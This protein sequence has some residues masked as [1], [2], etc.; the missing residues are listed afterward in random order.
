MLTPVAAAGLALLQIAAGIFHA[1]RAAF[2]KLPV[3]AL[4]L[5][6]A[7]FVIIGRTA[8]LA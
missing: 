4:L 8:Q 5:V 3:N 6:L 7:V 2:K 1:R